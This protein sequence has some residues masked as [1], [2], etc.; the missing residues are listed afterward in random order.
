MT[1]SSTAASWDMKIKPCS[2]VIEPLPAKRILQSK[3]SYWQFCWWCMRQRRIQHS[4]PC[5]YWFWN[6]NFIKKAFFLLPFFSLFFISP[7]FLFFVL[8]FE[9]GIVKF[10]VSL[11]FFSL[12]MTDITRK[13][14]EQ[15][16]KMSSYVSCTC[17]SSFRCISIFFFWKIM[18]VLIILLCFG[19]WTFHGLRVNCFNIPLN[20]MKSS[21]LKMKYVWEH[22]PSKHLQKCPKI[23]LYK[24]LRTKCVTKQ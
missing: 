3:L 22:P 4:C 8:L 23:S 20:V 16:E 18:Q 1:A 12:K 15:S 14:R 13:Q 10:V 19:Y 5:W 11:F 24:Q 2:S 9:F 7:F 21:L 6:G 17:F